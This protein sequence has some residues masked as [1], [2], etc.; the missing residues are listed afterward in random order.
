MES[1][2]NCTGGFAPEKSNKK[3]SDEE[4]ESRIAR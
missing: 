1:A 4:N 3:V 2:H